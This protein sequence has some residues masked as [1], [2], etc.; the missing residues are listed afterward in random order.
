MVMVGLRIK[1]YYQKIR[2]YIFWGE[3]VFVCTYRHAYDDDDDDDDHEQ[4]Q[5]WNSSAVVMTAIG[6]NNIRATKVAP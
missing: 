5:N 1:S 4:Q 3:F 6:S 2:G